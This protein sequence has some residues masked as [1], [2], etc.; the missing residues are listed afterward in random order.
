MQK[1]KTY[2]YYYAIA[3]LI[4]LAAAYYAA[5]S[6][7]GTMQQNNVGRLTNLLTNALATVSYFEE[8]ERLGMMDQAS[9]QQHAMDVLQS[10]NYAKDEYIWATNAEMV[11]VAAPLDPQIIGQSFAEVI[12]HDALRAIESKLRGKPGQVVNYTWSS[13]RGDVTTDI[14]SIAVVSL[15]WGWYLGSGVQE[16]TI[17]QA[18]YSMLI[19]NFGFVLIIALVAGLAMYI[20]I[21]RYN[22]VV[23]NHPKTILA[24]INHIS[25]GDLTHDFTINGRETGI[26]KGVLRMGQALKSMVSEIKTVSHD[27]ND[28]CN[29]LAQSSEIVAENT[30]IQSDQLSQASVSMMQIL[31]SVENVASKAS[32]TAQQTKL[33]E[34][35]TVKCVSTMTDINDQMNNLTLS[36]TANQHQLIKLQQQSQNISTLVE[37]IRAISDQTNLLA[38]NAAIEAARAGEFGRGFAVVADEVRSLAVRTQKSTIEIDKVVSTL[39]E[40]TALSVDIIQTNTTNIQVTH[41]HSANT[42]SAVNEVSSALT[43]IH[44]YSNEIANATE[45]QHSA[46]SSI[47]GIIEQLAYAAQSNNDEMHAATQ[48]RQELEKKAHNLSQI[49]AGFSV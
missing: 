40:D 33:A 12:G 24:L 6:V 32:V 11:F 18:F 42:L 9:A 39:S 5:A 30:T 38:L 22:L 37:E 27:L 14:N 31:G 36:L 45:E 41:Q 17:L 3:V 19:L 43:N 35:S 21:K 10:Y 7:K 25:Q 2:I 48:I 46:T 29:S 15:D 49:V 8:Q 26:Y 23:G 4:M 47:N 28:S 1:N 20:A 44:Q 16:R 34:N 13:T